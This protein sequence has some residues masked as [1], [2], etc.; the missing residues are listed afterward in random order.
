MFVLSSILIAPLLFSA[1]A[2]ISNAEDSLSISS[3]RTE[4]SYHY[5]IEIIIKGIEVSN[6]TF[7]TNYQTLYLLAHKG[8]LVSEVAPTGSQLIRL[9]FDFPANANLKGYFREDKPNKILISI[10]KA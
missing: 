1:T 5:K 6:V 10:P 3:N 9:A 2:G 7:E 4:N 8:G